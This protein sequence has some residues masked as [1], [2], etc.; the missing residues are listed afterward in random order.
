[1]QIRRQTGLFSLKALAAAGWRREAQFPKR[2]LR[3]MKHVAAQS[4][5]N[6][7]ESGALL[8]TVIA[9]HYLALQLR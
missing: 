3:L 7:V 4:V 5:E 8:D 6:D 1:L 2:G 9:A